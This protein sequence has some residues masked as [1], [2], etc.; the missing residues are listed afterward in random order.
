MGWTMRPGVWHSVMAIAIAALVLVAC[1]QAGSGASSSASLAASSSASSSAEASE[2]EEAS[3]SA[4][5]SGEEGGEYEITVSDTSAGDAL[6]GED[7][8]TLY[9]FDQDT[10]SEST[11]YDSCEDSWPPFTVDDGEEATAGDGVTGEIGTTT[12]DDGKTQVTYDGHPLYYYAGD[13]AAGDAE[14]DGIGGIW[15]IAT[16][17]GGGSASASRDYY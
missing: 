16:P 17:Q 12:R 14:G 11:C 3:G 4:E 2:S 9:T 10:G 8:M 7:G 13:N 1:S 5:A 6:A 15:H